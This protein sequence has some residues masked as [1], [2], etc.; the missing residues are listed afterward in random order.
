MNTG[1]VTTTPED[2]WAPFALRVEFGP[3]DLRPVTDDDIGALADLVREGLHEPG[4][5]PFAQPW[6]DAPDDE[7]PRNMA[8]YYWSSRASFGPDEWILD[9]VVRLAGEIVGV[10]GFRAKNYLVVRSG[11]T[12]SWLGRRYQGRGI[13]TMMRQAM[14]ALL[15]DHLD[16]EQITSAAFTDN[17]ASLAV[18]RKVG[19]VDNGTAREQRRPGELAISHKLLLTPDQFRRG[20]HTLTV[21]GITQLRRAIGL[22][23]SST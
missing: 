18:S 4:E 20:E 3:L 12:G 15:F 7:L 19:Y 10:Q 8:S 22:N 17:P 14:C 11:E 6:T 9:L 1:C 23:S 13:G 21:E 16:A 2:L 5:M